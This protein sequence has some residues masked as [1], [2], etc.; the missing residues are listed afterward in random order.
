MSIHNLK[1]LA[2]K[3]IGYLFISTVLLVRLLVILLVTLSE[4]SSQVDVQTGVKAC[5][6]EAIDY[7]DCD[8]LPDVIQPISVDKL[9]HEV[10]DLESLSW[11]ELRVYARHMGCNAKRKTDI[12]EYLHLV[13]RE[14]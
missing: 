7:L 6:D 3:T 9:N 11:N 4:L 1:L 2:L 5:L 12:L 8:G 14:P 10:V 13:S